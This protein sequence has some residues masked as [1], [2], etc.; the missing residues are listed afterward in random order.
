MLKLLIDVRRKVPFGNDKPF[1]I[2]LLRNRVIDKGIPFPGIYK[3]PTAELAAEKIE[4][5][6][7]KAILAY[8]H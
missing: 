3:K 1:R 8:E 6:T 5:L 2:K 4:A 7:R